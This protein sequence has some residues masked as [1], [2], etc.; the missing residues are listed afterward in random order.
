MGNGRTV[1]STFKLP[2]GSTIAVQSTD[3]TKHSRVLVC[4]TTGSRVNAQDHGAVL[5]T[6]PILC[7]RIGIITTLFQDSDSLF[8]LLSALVS[9]R[10]D[11]RNTLLPSSLLR[12][13]LTFIFVKWREEN[14]LERIINW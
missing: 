7:I 14:T 6:S 10:L 11:R 4:I 13:I 2:R 1:R 9:R 12:V 5:I 3:E 8:S